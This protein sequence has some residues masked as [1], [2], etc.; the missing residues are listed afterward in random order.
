MSTI[1]SSQITLETMNHERR[2]SQQKIH[3]SASC[4]RGRKQC[5]FR[6]HVHA[7]DRPKKA[8]PRRK[9]ANIQ[10]RPRS[11]PIAR[12]IRLLRI[13][14]LAVSATAFCTAHAN[15]LFSLRAAPMRPQRAPARSRARACSF[16]RPSDAAVVPNRSRDPYQP[17][18]LC[19]F[20]IFQFSS[21]TTQLASA[22]TQ[23]SLSRFRS[24]SRPRACAHLGLLLAPPFFSWPFLAFGGLGNFMIASRGDRSANFGPFIASRCRGATSA[25]RAGPN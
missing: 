21:P 13:S 24:E 18:G 5:A 20:V 2:D 9:R 8:R 22:K 1:R 15:S 7:R 25:R 6:L 17:R 3:H 14:L 10:F 19:N 11:I 16:L 4:I 23:P 12:T